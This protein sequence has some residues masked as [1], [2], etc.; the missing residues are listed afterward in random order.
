MTKGGQFERDISRQLS[1]WWTEGREDS[2]FWRSSQSGGRATQRAKVGKSTLNAAGDLCAQNAEAQKLLNIVVFE[3]KRGYQSI[4]I[5]DIFEKK[6][7]G[8]HDFIDQSRKSA[9]LA[10]VPGYAV[11]HKRDR[12]EAVIW[13]SS[14]YGSYP[15]MDSLANFLCDRNRQ[16]LL[17]VWETHFAERK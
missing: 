17:D 9:S 16:W 14:I 1:L 2:A 6:K 13:V 10:G 15:I 8:F 7:G 11:I 5:A 3:I 12:K 4:S